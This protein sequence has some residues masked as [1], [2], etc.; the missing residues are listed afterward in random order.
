MTRVALVDDQSLVREGFRLILELE[1]ITVVGEAA[2]GRDGLELIRNERPDVVLMDVRMPEMDGIEA[3]RRAAKA[4]PE[5]RVLVLTTFDLD[6][7]VFSA[8]QAGASGF[9]LKSVDRDQLV[10]AVRTVVA[11]DALVAPQITRRLLDRFM[12]RPP[13]GTL[14]GG[15]Q[16][17]SARELEVF[18]LVARGMTNAE[19]GETLF[20]SQSTVKTHVA[21][22]LDKLELR[23][24]VQVVI[25]A[26]ES[27]F[28]EPGS[29]R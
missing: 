21:R 10:S 22:I 7:Y 29:E 18:K 19:V 5:T 17:L 11:G 25:A 26:Y 2:N 13:T 12:S 14:S 15:M 1:G 3:T 23:D 16:D 6:E 20:V 9:L 8:F 24:R 28:I 27:G 4:S